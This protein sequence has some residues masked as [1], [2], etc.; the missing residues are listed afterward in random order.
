M[1]GFYSDNGIQNFE[2]NYV[3]V[4]SYQYPNP[5]Y[6]I[7]RQGNIIFETEKNNVSAIGEVSN[8]YFWVETVEELITGN[9]YTV[10]YYSVKDLSVVAT[11]HNHKAFDGASRSSSINNI[12]EAS[13]YDYTRYDEIHYAEDKAINIADYD[14][15]FVPTPDNWN[16]DISKLDAFS[17]VSD[18]GLTY[19]ISGTDNDLGQLAT[20]AA[21]NR[22]GVAFYAVLDSTGNFVCQPQQSISFLTHDGKFYDQYISNAEFRKNLC[23][24]KDVKSELWG[25]IDPYGNWKIQPQ[26]SSATPFSP[27]GYATVNK[28]TV[29]DTQGNTILSPYAGS[30]EFTYGTYTRSDNSASWSLTFDEN[31]ILTVKQTNFGSTISDTSKYEIKGNILVI[32][33]G[34]SIYVPSCPGIGTEAGE[35]IF[36]MEGNILTINGTEWTLSET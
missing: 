20:I 6:I 35:F 12:G 2:Y 8:G 25:Y 24:A 36:K 16:V 33:S 10:K 13:L 7:D 22:N 31:G 9:V 14:S 27:D 21:K 34:I 3:K 19:K 23:P 1:Y 17:S 29:I 15:S 28:T 30:T 26:Y 4:R 32:Y 5:Y 18:F 11:F